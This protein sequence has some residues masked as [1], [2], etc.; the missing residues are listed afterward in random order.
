MSPEKVACGAQIKNSSAG[1][2]ESIIP[3]PVMASKSFESWSKPYFKHVW[4]LNFC[5]CAELWSEKGSVVEPEPNFFL[6]PVKMHRL[7]A[8]QILFLYLHFFILKLFILTLFILALF[9]LILL[10]LTFSILIFFMR[11]IVYT[12]TYFL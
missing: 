1:N 12:G 4:K 8:D 11:Y 3:D 10:I 5:C 2:P 6:E 7:R 9:R